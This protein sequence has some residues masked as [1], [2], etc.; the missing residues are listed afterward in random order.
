MRNALDRARLRQATRLF[1]ASAGAG[2][3]PVDAAALSTLSAADLRAS[4]VFD[5]APQNSN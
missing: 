3:M 1:N 5:T 4:R 2:G